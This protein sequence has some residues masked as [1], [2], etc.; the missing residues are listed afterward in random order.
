VAAQHGTPCY[1]LDTDDVR[2]RCQE[3]RQTLPGVEIAYAA[4]AFLCSAMVRIVERQGLTLD[5]CSAGSWR[6][7]WQPVPG[8]ADRAAR[9]REDPGG[10]Q[11]AL[12]AGWAGRAGLRRRDRPA[13][14][15]GR[16]PRDVLIR[17]TRRWMP[18]AQGGGH[19]VADQK[20]GFGLSDGAVDAVRRVLER[21][22]CGWSAALPPGS[23]IGTVAPY[24]L[25]ARRMVE[26]LAELD[27]RFGWHATQLNLGGGH[28][29]RTPA[30][31][32][33]W[34][35]SPLPTGAGGSAGR[36]PGAPGPRPRLTVEP[37]RAIVA[38]PRWRSTGLPR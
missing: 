20:F 17:V 18:G 38:P 9:Q 37:G 4:K 6:W 7:P 26:L 24:E 36:L 11:G 31:T 33:R 2:L 35:W 16:H 22:S 10:P 5:V 19:R 14:R 15:A 3:Y 12:S 1:L 8:L 23:Q 34:T 29:I 21:P 30:P 32:P 28:G 25:A 13:R 27:H